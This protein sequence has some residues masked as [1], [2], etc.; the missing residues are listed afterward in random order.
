MYLD[1]YSSNESYITGFNQGAWDYDHDS[2]VTLDAQYVTPTFKTWMN[3]NLVA[4]GESTVLSAGVYKWTD[5]TNDTSSLTGYWT[6]NINGFAYHYHSD[7]GGYNYNLES[8]GAINSITLNDQSDY[9]PYVYWQVSGDVNYFKGYSD[10]SSYDNYYIQIYNDTTVSSVFRN[11]FLNLFSLSALPSNND[12][13]IYYECDNGHWQEGAPYPLPI[14]QGQDFVLDYYLEPGYH[15]VEIDYPDGNFTSYYYEL[16]S[17]D[18]ARIYVTAVYNDGMTVRVRSINPSGNYTVYYDCINCAN[19]D[20]YQSAGSAQT[21]SNGNLT[22]TFYTE[23][24]YLFSSSVGQTYAYPP[25]YANIT[26]EVLNS[27]MQLKVTISGVYEGIT[28]R[29]EPTDHV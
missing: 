7:D 10:F 4:V 8:S 11:T 20:N 25:S 21:D 26:E 19:V 22:L 2:Y 18:V 15:G 16:I 5:T 23:S 14:K 12:C 6:E 29:V 9:D 3:R 27:G 1:F 24:G 28:L 13:H 17:E